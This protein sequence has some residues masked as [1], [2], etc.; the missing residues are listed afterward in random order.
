MAIV[1]IPLVED[2]EVMSL[3]LTSVLAQF[4]CAITTATN[5]P[6]ALRYISS[7]RYDMLLS[8][9][10]MPGAGDGG[11][12]TT[13]AMSVGTREPISSALRFAWLMPAG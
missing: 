5:V 10:H 11:A 3:G 7:E 8:D 2:D 9:L 6:Q 12:Q 1:K 13:S 4:G